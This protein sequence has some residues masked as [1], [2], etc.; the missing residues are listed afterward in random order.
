VN[1]SKLSS[2]YREKIISKIDCQIWDVIIIGG[3]ITG[4]GTAL[5]CMKF[6]WK[7]LLLEK[8]DF[9][10]GTS[11]KSSGMI[12]GGLRYLEQQNFSL[13][14]EA[15]KE[16]FILGEIASKLVKPSRFLF[17][18]YNSFFNVIKIKIGLFLY[19]FFAGKY[20][21]ENHQ[22]ISKSSIISL[23][24][25][26]ESKNLVGGFLY[27]DSLVSDAHLVFSN[28]NTAKKN[29]LELINYFSVEEIKKKPI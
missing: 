2:T 28:L 26:I 7:T 3:G 12:H 18:I 27:S 23:Y 8:G 9:A 1:L 4:A 11:N 15:L 5:G 20:N 22:F 10:S 6:G 17:P 25:Y 21:L 16:R 24:P 19:D 13:V 29:G 14:K